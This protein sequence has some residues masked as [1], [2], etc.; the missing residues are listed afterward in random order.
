MCINLCVCVRVSPT[1]V[2]N[3]EYRKVHAGMRV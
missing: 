2:M 3:E 1:S